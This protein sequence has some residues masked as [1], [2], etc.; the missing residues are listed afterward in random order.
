MLKEALSG[1]TSKRATVGPDEN[2]L[3]GWYAAHSGRRVYK[4]SG[5]L[6]IYHRHFARYR[7]RSP[8]VLE[9]GVSYGGSLEMWRDYFGP[10]CRLYGVDIDPRCKAFE[11]G[12]TTILIGDQA[13]RAFLGRLRAE[14]PRLDI[15]IDDGGHMME[16][17]IATFEELYPHVADDGVYLCEDLHTSYWDEFGGGY[18]KDSSFIEF[19]KDLIDQ[20][21]AWHWKRGQES[22]VNDF[23]RTAHSMHY[24][25]S[26][27]V[28]EKRRMQRPAAIEAGEPSF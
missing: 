6:E 12:T 1:Q 16:Q 2:P 23:T 7:G 17:Q 28:I 26:V 13:E 15:L 25:D 5:Y 3:V 22:A 10:G 27:L 24:Y 19:S 9:I 20:L 11:D 4:L 14:L 18:R 21:N 8:V